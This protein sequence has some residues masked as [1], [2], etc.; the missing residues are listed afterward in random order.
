MFI[1]FELNL[2]IIAFNLWN[3]RK[4]R[5]M[6]V[7]F[8]LKNFMSFRDEHIFSLVAANGLREKDDRLS[9]NVVVFS[10]QIELLKTAVVYGA[11]ASGKSNLLQ[12]LDFYT[13]CILIFNPPGI[14][15]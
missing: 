12:A 8:R 11:N 5:L 3:Y 2:A 13:S 10:E 9:T 4:Y 14:G 7:Q 15:Y 6:L 1:V